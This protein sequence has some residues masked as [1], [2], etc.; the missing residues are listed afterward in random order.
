MEDSETV[1]QP[2]VDSTGIEMEGWSKLL[3]PPQ[4]LHR[5]TAV[6]LLESRCETDILPKRVPDGFG[7]VSAEIGYLDTGEGW[8][9]LA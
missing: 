6:Q 5:F 9:G 3:D 4:F 8:H 1:V 2:G 7:K